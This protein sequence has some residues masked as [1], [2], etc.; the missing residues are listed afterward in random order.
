MKTAPFDCRAVPHRFPSL[1]ALILVVATGCSRATQ[2]QSPGVRPN[3]TLW[4]GP[5]GDETGPV[6]AY[7]NVYETFDKYPGYAIAT[8]EI[9]ESYDQNQ[10]LNHFAQ[11]VNQCRKAFGPAWKAGTLMRVS[12]D[13]L[14]FTPFS[15]DFIVIALH[16]RRDHT[17]AST[18]AGSYRI[19]WLIPAADI[20]NE[21]KDASALAAKAFIDRKPFYFAPPPDPTNYSPLKQFHWLIIEHHMAT[22][23]GTTPPPAQ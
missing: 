18:F 17:N 2:N 11:S 3:Q 5:S 15:P 9:D 1:L 23:A 13:G 22:A 4:E 10:D 7:Q 6:A 19:A 20:F 16:N 8:Y 14:N 21:N 12:D